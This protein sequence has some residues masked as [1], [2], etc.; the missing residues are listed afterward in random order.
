M[1]LVKD[2]ARAAAQ[3]AL[4]DYWDGTIPVNP[5]RIAMDLGMNVY[6]AYLAEDQSGMIRKLE[7][8]PA[9]IFLNANEPPLRQNFTCAHELGHWFE[10]RSQSDEEYSFVDHRNA[11]PNDAHEWFAEHF[12]ANLLMPTREFIT[13]ADRGL[14][15]AELSD[16]FVVS[17]PAIR[18]RLRALN[19]PYGG[20]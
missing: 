3:R 6:R 5:A 15:V 11:T 2:V 10:R 18:N 12:A 9:E 8:E 19:M 4:D 14:S 20:R 13:A 1:A 16:Y 7:N 17:Q